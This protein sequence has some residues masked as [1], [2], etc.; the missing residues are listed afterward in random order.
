MTLRQKRA[1]RS[2]IIRQLSAMSRD[3]WIGARSG[4][5]EALE[6]ELRELERLL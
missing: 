1:R 2:E 5:Y 3:G 4:D 6:R